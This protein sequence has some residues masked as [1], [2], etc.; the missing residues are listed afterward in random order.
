MEKPIASSLGY[1]HKRGLVNGARLIA[2]PNH[3]QRPD[4][5]EI[6]VLVIHAISLPPQCYGNQYVEDLFTGRLDAN[7][8]P[9][10]MD[11][12]G[13][14]VSSHFYIKRSGEIIQFVA[15][16]RRAWHAGKSIFN[17]RQRVNDFSIGVEL[18]GCDQH[19]FENPQY[20]VLGELTLCLQTVYPLITPEN[21]VGHD[22]ISPHRKTDPGPCFDWSRYFNSI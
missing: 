20:A 14:K 2:S 4:N 22:A 6:D 11:L 19:E 7:A 10:F 13:Q 8:D 3:D 17:G 1:C 9:Y 21:I 12:A 18:E 5:T 15:T 16:H